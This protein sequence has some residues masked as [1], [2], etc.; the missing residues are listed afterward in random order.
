MATVIPGC[1]EL[2]LVGDNEYKAEVSL[3]VGPVRGKFIAT[4][5]LSDLDPPKAAKLSG[6]LEGPLGSSAGSGNVTLDAQDGG[7]FVA[8]KYR[9][10]IGGKVAAIGGR[11]LEGAAKIVVGQFFERLIAQVEEKPVSSS[12]GSWWQKLL[13]IL[14]LGK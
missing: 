1:H 11:M 14:G 13:S 5:R 3:G 10:E 7:T 9:V 6:S 12:G 4:V 8:Y 2:N